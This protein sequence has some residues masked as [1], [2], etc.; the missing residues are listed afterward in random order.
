MHLSPHRWPTAQGKDVEL[1]DEF[2]FNT[3]FASK[4]R[5][6]KVPLISNKSKAGRVAAPG[7]SGVQRAAGDTGGTRSGS[8]GTGAGGHG[9]QGAGGGGGVGGVGGV[10]DAV[11][12]SRR[13]LCVVC[14]MLPWLCA[15]AP[16]CCGSRA[17]LSIA[18]LRLGHCVVWQRGGGGGAHNEDPQDAGQ[19]QLGGGGN[20]AAQ[21][22]LPPHTAAHQEAHRKPDRAGVPGAGRRRQVRGPAVPLRGSCV[23]W[24]AP[25]LLTVCHTVRVACCMCVARV[26]AG[27]PLRCLTAIAT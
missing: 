11:E 21:Q 20:E 9:G 10:S 15:P 24:S 6:V 23:W 8:G 1:D 4:L 3:R 5:R 7:G 19:Q 12:E 18:S 14:V 25:L 17:L 2:C 26:Q 13:H 27:V 22:S 16:P